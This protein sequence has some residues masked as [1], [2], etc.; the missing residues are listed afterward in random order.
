MT[1]AEL[2]ELEVSSIRS[3]VEQHARDYL[4]GRVLDFGCGQSPYQGI[5]EAAGG[6]YAPF[7]RVA[8]PANVSGEDVGPDSIPDNE[9]FDAALCTQVIQYLEE[10]YDELMKL[11]GLIRPNGHLVLT[12]PTC[13]PER[14][15][16]DLWR[17]TQAG[18]EKLLRWAGFEVLV[19][20][21]RAGVALA[22]G[23]ELSLGWGAVAR[24]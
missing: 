1:A 13:W 10:P 18:V 22:P 12:G 17:F 6:V 3:F 24:A 15:P 16:D 21:P 7:D 4:T 19:L 20:Q 9:Q 8:F 14:E 5:I 11:R 2:Q 23:F